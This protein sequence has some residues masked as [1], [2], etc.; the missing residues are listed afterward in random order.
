MTIFDLLFLVLALTAIV[1][2]VAVLIAVVRGR[3]PAAA[4]LLRRLGVGVLIYFMVLLAVSLLTPRRYLAVGDDQCSDDWCIAVAQATHT[5]AGDSVDWQ[6]TFRLTSHM[7]RGF[8][9]EL[10]V[11]AYLRDSQGRRYD[12][13]GGPD[14]PPFD[15]RL[16]PQQQLTTIRHFRVPLDVRDLG[17]IVSKEGGP[18]DPGCCIIG[19]EGSL[20]HKRTVVRLD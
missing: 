11:V 18:P 3:R 17:L 2:L 19:G 10:G 14:G 6:L 16:A 1:T 13:I 9:R 20:L 15:V 12:P 4:R 8:Q 7:G 5:P